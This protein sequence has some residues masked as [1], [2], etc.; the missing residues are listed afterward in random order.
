[1]GVEEANSFDIQQIEE[2][3]IDPKWLQIDAEKESVGI[4]EHHPLESISDVQQGKL[5]AQ[6]VRP[7]QAEK[8]NQ[9]VE[10][11]SRDRLESTES[12]QTHKIKQENVKHHS[13]KPEMEES[14][15]IQES[16][17]I[18]TI[19]ELQQDQTS[20]EKLRS[21]PTDYKTYSVKVQKSNKLESAESL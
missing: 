11:H 6:K 21:K 15:G 12:I 16:H 10:V 5:D 17:V 18:E 1:M 2:G 4:K 19:S 14:V 8:N 3:T 13:L 9:S 7:T 20:M